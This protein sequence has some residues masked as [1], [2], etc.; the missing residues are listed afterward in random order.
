MRGNTPESIKMII[1]TELINGKYK[2]AYKY[3]TILKNSIFY[4]RE[5]REFEKLLFDDK[6]VD[7]HPELGKIKRLK[8]KHDFFVLSE[9]PAANIDLI[10]AADSANRIALEYKL[11]FLLLQKDMKGIAEILPFYSKMGYTQIPKNVEE[12]VVAYSLLN[13]KKYPEFE[14]ITVRPETV[15]RFN[16]YYKI[17]AMIL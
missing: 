17:L 1:K 6:A 7:L 11:A 4:K 5:A 8:P 15:T 12:A 14:G 13:L 16:E 2:S 10:L 3:I 9:N